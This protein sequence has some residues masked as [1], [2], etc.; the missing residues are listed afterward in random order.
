MV[1]EMGDHHPTRSWHQEK[2]FF[3]FGPAPVSRV[4]LSLWQAAE[5]VFLVT[6]ILGNKYMLLC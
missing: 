2:N 6:K 5:P 1:F 4:W 3:P